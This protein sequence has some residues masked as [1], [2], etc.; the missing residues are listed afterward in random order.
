[1]LTGLT[2]KTLNIKVLFL[3]ILIFSRA[4]FLIESNTE[5]NHHEE[6]RK[7]GKIREDY[8]NDLIKALIP[9]VIFNISSEIDM[10]ADDLY[11]EALEILNDLSSKMPKIN[12]VSRWS[13]SWLLDTIRHIISKCI[14]KQITSQQE[15]LKI[16][17]YKEGSQIMKVSSFLKKAASL[18][19][20]DALYLLGDMHFY[21]NF[22]HP[23]DLYKAFLFYKEHAERTGNATTQFNVGLFYAVGM[24]KQVP[25]DQ[26]KALLYFMFSASQGNIRAEMILAYRYYM[27]IGIPQSCQIAVE[28]YKKVADKAMNYFDSG[29]PGGISLPR[30]PRKFADDEGGIYGEGASVVSSGPDYKR[31]KKL[32]GKILKIEKKG[33]DNYVD[34]YSYIAEKGDVEAQLLLAKLFYL[35]TS[36][37]DRDFKKSFSYF[38]KIAKLYW[39]KNGDPYDEKYGPGAAETARYLGLMYFRGEGV[40]QNFRIA[41]IWFQRGINIGDA[42]CQNNMGMIYLKGYGDTN[43]DIQKAAEL[44]KAASDQGLSAAKV[45]LAKIYLAQKDY[46]KAYILFELAWDKNPV[47]AAYY[48]ATMS[49]HEF[50]K[51]SSCQRTL[52]YYKYVSERIGSVYSTLD[53]AEK[54][55]ENNN[56]YMTLITSLIAAE[57]GYE[58]GQYN[59]A[60]LLD[61][62]K[63]YLFRYQENYFPMSDELSLIYYTRAAKQNNIDAMVRMGD[64]YL[65]GIGTKADSSKAIKC[66]MSAADTGLSSLAAWNLGWMYENGIG[67]QQD[68]H[69][70]KR[71]YTNALLTNSEAWLPVTLSL[72]KLRIRSLYKSIMNG[73]AL[74]SS[75]KPEQENASIIDKSKNFIKKIQDSLRIDDIEEN[76][77]TFEIDYDD[78]EFYQ[79]KD[80]FFETIVILLLCLFI[81]F[82]IYYRQARL[83]VGLRRNSNTQ[84]HAE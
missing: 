75:N 76:I 14:L 21:G 78:Q 31:K 45:N 56:I 32:I 10:N 58:A 29:P 57:Q 20:N 43:I 30:L 82:M 28:Y 11:A 26:A 9:D 62:E 84:H 35:G 72:I 5:T 38:K 70:A 77:E 52:T 73:T 34:Y 51:E 2:I 41:K 65:E 50:S 67:I 80:D 55:Y 48:L 22:S 27:G 47:E 24:V 13:F 61:K 42:A 83:H 7:K 63:S 71:H 25:R 15:N 66:F 36:S 18:G 49:Y 40:P 64:Y 19:H 37:I 53:E 81:T 17:Q 74:N 6:N 16:R 3:F 33:M 8:K 1:M 60:W 54:T 44:F 23:L 12:V 69:L 4:V 39:K 79:S 68:F 46:T 59:V